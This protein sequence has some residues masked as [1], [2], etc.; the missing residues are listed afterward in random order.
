MSDPNNLEWL[1]VEG[2]FKELMAKVW[3]TVPK[4]SA[5]YDQHRIVFYQAMHCFM[6]H[7]AWMAIVLLE[8]ER[9]SELGK[10]TDRIT[11]FFRDREPSIRDL[12]QVVLE[13][14]PKNEPR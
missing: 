1:I 4:T 9:V 6:T 14:S 12:V 5:Q 8:E 2:A 3:P 13:P 7:L 10:I 11:T